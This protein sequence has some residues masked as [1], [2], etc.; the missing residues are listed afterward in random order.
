[1]AY[2]RPVVTS[3]FTSAINFTYYQGAQTGPGSPSTGTYTGYFIWNS[4][5]GGRAQAFGNALFSFDTQ[6]RVNV[7]RVK[8]NIVN[9]LTITCTNSSNTLTTASAANGVF[10]DFKTVG[11]DNY[12][13]L[14]ASGPNITANADSV[15]QYYEEIPFPSSNMTWGG[16]HEIELGQGRGGWRASFK[17]SAGV[18]TPL[19]EL[20]L[21]G[22]LSAWNSTSQ[23]CNY[24]RRPGASSGYTLNSYV[25]VLTTSSNFVYYFQAYV[26]GEQGNGLGAPI[27]MFSDTFT[28]ITSE[29]PYNPAN[30]STKAT[31]EYVLNGPN[32]TATNFYISSGAL[33]IRGT[34]RNACALLDIQTAGTCPSAA[35]SPVSMIKLQVSTGEF[36]ISLNS[37]N[38]I[39]FNSN[40]SGTSKAV[41]YEVLTT[42]SKTGAVTASYPVTGT[43]SGLSSNA[44]VWVVIAPSFSGTSYPNNSIS[45]YSI[46]VYIQTAKPTTSNTAEITYTPNIATFAPYISLFTRGVAT[47]SLLSLE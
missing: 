40:I 8:A 5:D 4:G 28:R 38:A 6:S 27:K 32:N 3:N 31:G 20:P 25:G 30:A 46:Y 43:S 12:I 14:R 29:S 35:D 16:V 44:I 9:G 23:A 24:L 11:T 17:D 22:T 18:W 45:S 15:L 39:W 19:I 47:P 37:S 33:Q 13:V 21:T 7:I 2:L 42:D 34:D 10:L 1:M 26:V 36:A 41:T